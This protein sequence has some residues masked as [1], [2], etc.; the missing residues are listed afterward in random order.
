[1]ADIDNLF[2]C[3]HETLGICGKIR[4][5]VFVLFDIGFTRSVNEH[6]VY[7]ESDAEEGIAVL[8]VEFTVAVEIRGNGSTH[9]GE[10]VE[11]PFICVD[12]LIRI[13]EII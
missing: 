4:N 7:V 12:E 8:V 11:S 9:F 3:R 1:M 13:F 10:L 6:G 5:V 2:I